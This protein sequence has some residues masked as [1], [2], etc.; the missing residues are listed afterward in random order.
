MSVDT[1]QDAEE[2][3]AQ[4]REEAALNEREARRAELR[5]PPVAETAGKP[6][7]IITAP[8][9]DVRVMANMRTGRLEDLHEL[10]VSIRETGLLHP[11]LVRETGE[12]AKPYELLAGQRRFAAMELVD[13]AA[14]GALQWRFTLIEGISRREAL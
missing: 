3:V 4:M 2:E 7:T 10:A 8:L 13:E 5:Q 14:E 12:E 6:H 9:S 11:P 1:F